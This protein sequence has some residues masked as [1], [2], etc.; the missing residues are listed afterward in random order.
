MPN[1]VI[2][3]MQVAHRAALKC[4]LV[5]LFLALSEQAQPVPGGAGLWFRKGE[6]REGEHFGEVR[7]KM[8][9]QEKRDGRGR[10]GGLRF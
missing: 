8:D 9:V 6:P 3:L 1:V 4:R 10:L 2:G 5:E 7:H